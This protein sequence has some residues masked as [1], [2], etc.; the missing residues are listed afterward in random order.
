[1]AI[2][3]SAEHSFGG[4]AL[5]S[6]REFLMVVLGGIALG[7]VIGLIAS[8]I[9]ARFDDHMLEITLTTLTAYGS[10]LGAE[11]LHVSPVI[12]VLTAGL[13]W[14]N[15]GRRTGMS[16][17]TQVA[18]YSFWDYAAF[19][20]NSLV[21]LLIG[22]ETQLPAMLASSKAIAW[23]VLAMQM[24]RIIAI[25]GLMP[26]VN[27]FSHSVSFVWQHVLVWAKK[28]L[29]SLGFYLHQF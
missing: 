2:G 8:A 10:F 11:G 3:A 18:V 17:T 6:V 27:R 28:G 20:V 9:T 16:P 26:V 19:V 22:L 13:I 29:S 21:F 1:L 23:G 14:G 4:L 24:A 15:Y 25:Y 5:D 7:A 12:A